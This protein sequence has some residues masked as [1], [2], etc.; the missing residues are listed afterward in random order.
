MALG[1]YRTSALSEQDR[2]QRRRLLSMTLIT[3]LVLALIG[4]TI[5]VVMLGKLRLGDMR[6]M[7]TY[8]LLGRVH[9]RPRRG[10]RHHAAAETRSRTPS[11]PAITSSRRSDC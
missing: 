10:R 8:D 3:C 5:H 6:R 4:G 9:A 7:A 2:Q 11:P 1:P